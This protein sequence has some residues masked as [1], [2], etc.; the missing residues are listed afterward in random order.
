MMQAFNSEI[1]T[2]LSAALG[3]SL[4]APFSGR[5]VRMPARQ[6]DASAH[7]PR[8]ADAAPAL[9]ADYGSLYGAPLVRRVRL[10]SGWLLFDFTGAFFGALVSR[11]NAALP[12]PADDGGLHAVNRMLALARHGGE[13]CPDS[14]VLRRALLEAVC[15]GE[16][17]A[18]RSRADRAAETL[19]HSFPPRERPSRMQECGALGG[20][21]ARLLYAAARE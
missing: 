21:L 2:A 1:R 4:G 8:G 17:P 11:V 19:F 10:V 13:G 6:A 9:C 7:L 3:S 14:P 5:S 15:A 18:A 16:S 12:L 20:A